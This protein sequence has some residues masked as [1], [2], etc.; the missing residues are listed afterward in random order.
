MKMVSLKHV[1]CTGLTVFSFVATFFAVLKVM[2][3][4]SKP[5]E[6]SFEHHLF[7]TFLDNITLLQTVLYALLMNLM[8]V[9]LFILQHSLMKSDF[10]KRFWAKIG[11]GIAERSLYNLG[12]S[13]VLLVSVSIFR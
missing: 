11:F 1:T 4:L 10:V 13:I 8:W 9:I 5:M 6:I 12:T 7:N 2:I 3:F